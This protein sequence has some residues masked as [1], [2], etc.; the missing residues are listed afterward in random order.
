M[1]RDNDNRDLGMTR[2]I[3][4]RD[5]LN[6]VS[7]GVGG[8]LL[9][10]NAP[11][12]SALEDLA[13]KDP[14]SGNYYPP[15]LTGLRGSYDATYQYAHA[16]RDD[17]FWD[18][19]PKPSAT[20]ESYDLVVVGG[21]ISG[22]AAAYF[23]RQKFGNK[24]R[25][26][27]L[28]NHDDFGGHAKRN[29]FTAGNRMVLSYGGT[30]SIESPDDYS[31]V[32]KGVLTDLGID[33][34]VFYKAYDQKLYSKLGTAVFFDRE[35]FGHDRL[36]TGL[37]TTPW[38]EF[39]AQ[40]PLSDAARRDIARVYVDKVDYLPNLTRDEKRAKLAKISYADFLTKTCK[41]TPEAL[42]F[43]Q[44]WSHD[45]FGVGIDAAA[46]L[47]CYEA[48]D[49]YGAIF[50]PGFDGLDLGEREKE[51]PYIFHFPDGNASIARLLVRSLIS[52][53]I[54]GHDMYDVVTARADYNQLDRA[55]SPVRIRLNSTVVKV[56][57]DG[58]PAS[59]KQVN[60]LYMRDGR[61]QGVRAGHVVMACYNMMVPYL[62]PELPPHQKE[63]LHYGVKVP[64]LYTHVA[65]R[66]WQSFANLG[67]QHIVSPG[68]YHCYSALDFP[69]SLGEYKFPSQPD[70]PA[71]LFMLRTPCKPGLPARDQ[72]RYGHGELY[73]T[74]YATIE[75]NVRDQLRRMLTS[76]GFDPA[77]DIVAITVNRWTHGY[78]YEYSTLWDPDFAPDERPC[79]IGRQP[80]GRITIANSDAG[81]KAYTDAAIDQAWRAVGEI[82]TS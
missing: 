42:P 9:A 21:G 2:D 60:V 29:E 74:T 13:T 26:L 63:A 34:S 39:L 65:L 67:M 51:E 4:R 38:P 66:N 61:L 68:S 18:A 64:L 6:G 14:A 33:T 5:F 41:V 19:A 44:T 40:A 49:D 20:T 59:A 72:Y 43:F 77:R 7:L 73:Q 17:A 75:R 24:A 28:D 47:S 81:A 79:V 15:A 46:A 69:V 80:F 70:E 25:I 12:L 37:N 78:A 32:T 23:Y 58:P 36:V 82:R 57:H 71:V 1:S 10:S 31:Q 54:P 16:L 35:T 52:A 27:I 22:L 11:L 48:G 30:Q 45:L 50:Y 55:S 62:C 8:A 76:Q 53:A 3:T 56:K